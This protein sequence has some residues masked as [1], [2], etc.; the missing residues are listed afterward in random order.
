M[1]SD[2]EFV[3]FVLGQ[4]AGAG[5]VSAKKMFGEYGVYFNGKMVALICD[6]RFLVKPT[7]AGGAF[8]G[9][10]V[11]A[12]P[13]PGAKPCFLIEDRLEESE[14]LCELVRLTEPEL[15]VPKKRKKKRQ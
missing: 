11:E 5:E 9:E 7:E 2:Q 12:P 14:W 15:P 8:I 13:Y 10:P 6:N 1:A 4:L 3:D